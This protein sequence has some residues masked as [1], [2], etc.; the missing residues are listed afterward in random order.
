MGRGMETRE[1]RLR[2]RVG[3]SQGPSHLNTRSPGSEEGVGGVQESGGHPT[4]TPEKPSVGQASAGA[5]IWNPWLAGKGGGH[6]VWLQCGERPRGITMLLNQLWG[7]LGGP[8]EGPGT[9]G[10]HHPGLG[11]RL[12]RGSGPAGGLTQAPPVKGGGG[13]THGLE[14]ETPP[15]SPWWA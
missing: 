3:Q 12:E 6:R 1:K 13:K 2:I 10:C 5:R 14:P 8:A 11:G 7:Q 4:F 15:R 9:G